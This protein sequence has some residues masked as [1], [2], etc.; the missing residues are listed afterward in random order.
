MFEIIYNKP[1]HSAFRQ[2]RAM[3]HTSVAVRTT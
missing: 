3:L 1:D 2:V